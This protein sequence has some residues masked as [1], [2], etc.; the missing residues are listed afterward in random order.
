MTLP[1]RKGEPVVVEQDE[2]PRETSLEALAKLGTPFRAGG[3]VT[4]G[5]ASGVNDGACAI[6]VASERAAQRMASSRARAS[7]ARRSRAC[8]RASWAWGR[9]PHRRS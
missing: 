1:A 5:N 3:T 2:H 6:L 4:A 9:R 8:R 7:W